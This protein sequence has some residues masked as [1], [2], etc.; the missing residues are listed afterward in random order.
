[1]KRM[2][3]ALTFTLMASAAF[4]DNPKCTSIEQHM[5]WLEQMSTPDWETIIVERFEGDPVQEA[6]KIWNNRPPQSNIEADL[7]VIFK[8]INK[9]LKKFSK[10]TY[11]GFFKNGCLTDSGQFVEAPPEPEGD[12][13]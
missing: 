2:F 11:I 5:H 1:M 4:A 13:A 6:V 12:D 9:K 10:E 3:L 8:G 7:V